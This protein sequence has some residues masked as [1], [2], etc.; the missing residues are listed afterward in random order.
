MQ[1]AGWKENIKVK[2]TETKKKKEENKKKDTYVIG[3]NPF[4]ADHMLFI[5]EENAKRRNT[6]EGR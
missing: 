1:R 3:S 2:E 5:Q 6:R 4:D